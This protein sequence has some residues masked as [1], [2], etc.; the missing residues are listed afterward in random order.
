MTDRVLDRLRGCLI[1][2]A[3]GDSLGAAVEFQPP[4]TFQLVTDY[5]G[6]G[7]HRLNP[8]E[9]TGNI[10]IRFDVKQCHG[11]TNR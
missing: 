7:P 2:L 5:R 6:G 3:V 4:G 10:Q 11:V 1:G 9:W 8:G